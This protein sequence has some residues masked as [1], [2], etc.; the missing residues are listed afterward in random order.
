MEMRARRTAID[1]VVLSRSCTAVA[2]TSPS[3]FTDPASTI[4]AWVLS[5]TMLID[6]AAAMPMPLLCL[7]C[8]SGATSSPNKVGSETPSRGS[9]SL[10]ALPLPPLSGSDP[11][12]A[13]AGMAHCAPS[14]GSSGV[15]SMRAIRRVLLVMVVSAAAV[16]VQNEELAPVII[17]MIT[18]HEVIRDRIDPDLW[19]W[20]MP[21]ASRPDRRSP[22]RRYPGLR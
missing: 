15:Q 20:G 6:T 4:E 19:F 21:R 22:P 10:N 14:S 1:I 12:D 8:P 2:E 5:V 17:A 9:S 3:A 18:A 7:V 16:L 11:V 13:R